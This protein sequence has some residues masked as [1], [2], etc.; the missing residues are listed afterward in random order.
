MA[1][2]SKSLKLSDAETLAILEDMRQKQVES[3]KNFFV[4]MAK[5]VTTDLPG[6]LTDVADRLLGNTESLGD[7]DRSA[8]YFEAMT[9]IKTKSGS[10]GVDELVGGMVNPVGAAKAVIVPAVIAKGFKAAKEGKKLLDEGVDAATVFRATGTFPG[11]TDA[12]LR[13]IISDELATLQFGPGLIER[14]ASPLAAYGPTQRLSLG[15]WENRTLGDI[16]DHPELFAKIP[17]LKNIPVKAQFGGFES[18]AYSPGNKT[19]Y[20]GATNTP[21][22]FKSILMHEVQHGIQDIF[23]FTPGG[24]SGMFYADEK[25][26]DLARDAL[27][28]VYSNQLNSSMPMAATKPF[29]EMIKQAQEILTDASSK[30]F[31][32]YE[33]LGGEVEARA[34]QKLLEKPQL[35]NTLPLDY[36]DVDNLTDMI[37]NPESIPKVDL[38]PKVKAI[39]EFMGRNP[40]FGTPKPKK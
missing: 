11:V 28:N 25:T 23:D 10:G 21:E 16:L 32:N 3:V 34:V 4:G 33:N 24:N 8:Q 19:I 30:A 20:M 22:K 38:D 39:L 1:E 40:S 2:K 6:F 17:E 7:N 15:M 5:G 14:S 37:S 29:R 12:A 9:G 35:A 18:G 27:N 31:R 13:G 36:Y 26:F